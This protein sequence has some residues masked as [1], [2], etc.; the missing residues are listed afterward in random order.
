[1][2]TKQSVLD[3]CLD[4]IHQVWNIDLRNFQPTMMSYRHHMHYL[5]LYWDFGLNKFEIDIR[6][7]FSKIN[8]EQATA[9]KMELDMAI[10]L[11]NKLNKALK[12]S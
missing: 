12:T 4:N 6:L 9:M 2:L 8:T 10:I 5:D 7:E 11:C 1:M 3:N